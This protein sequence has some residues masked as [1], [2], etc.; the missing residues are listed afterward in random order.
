MKPPDGTPALCPV[1]GADLDFKFMCRMEEINAM[2]IGNEWIAL[3]DV[4]VNV[5]CGDHFELP[6]AGKNF[7]IDIANKVVL[8]GFLRPKETT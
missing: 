4:P 3:E 7:T 5:V 2:V 1:C 8:H 6:C